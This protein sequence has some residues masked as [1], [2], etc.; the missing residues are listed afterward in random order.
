MI[1]MSMHVQHVQ[2]V[3]HMKVGA[4]EGQCRQVEQRD[5]GRPVDV[6]KLLMQLLQR[7]RVVGLG[8]R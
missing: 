6:T 3:P 1:S 4:V 5:A 7:K 2:H 8:R